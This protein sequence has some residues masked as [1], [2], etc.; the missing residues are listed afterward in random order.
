MSRWISAILFVLFSCS[1]GFSQVGK[2]TGYWE[3]VYDDPAAKSIV[4]VAC[5]DGVASGFVVEYAGSRYLLTAAHVVSGVD[6]SAG[7]LTDTVSAN[8]KVCFRGGHVVPATV[9]AKD[10]DD[11]ICVLGCDIPEYVTALKVATVQPKPGDECQVLGLG[12]L[13]L[14]NATIRHFRAHAA[15]GTCDTTI[16]DTGGIA[17]DSGGPILNA[18]D[19]VVGIVSGG[20]RWIETKRF[21]E[22]GRQV[23]V[24]WPVSGAGAFQIRRVLAGVK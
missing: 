11:D 1:A 8:I 23:S 20:W 9:I 16:V 22:E 18:N 7:R 19:E 5:A 6:V 4:T 3:F 15:W 2:D 12:G 24:S 10:L 21:L 14:F 13:T 17:G